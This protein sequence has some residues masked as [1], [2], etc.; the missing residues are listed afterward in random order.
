MFNKILV[1]NRSEI[2][3]R[4]MRSAQ[5]LGVRTVAVFSDADS[6]APHVDF[7]DEA[8]HIG[9]S[10]ASESYLVGAKII[11]AAKHT[12]AEAIHPGYGFLSENAD[13]AAACED[14]GLCFIGP[15][16]EVIRIMGSK[17]D[18]KALMQTHG[19]PVVPGFFG[20][21]SDE[22]LASEAEK[23]GFPVLIK[24]SAG[25]GGR[26]MRLVHAAPE[27][28]GALQSARREA[29][30]AFA[31][32]SVLLEKYIER[33]RH[34]EV[35][36]F[37]DTHGNIIHLFERDCSVQR[38]YQKLIEEA[39]ASELT[40]GQR[41]HIHQAA[42]TAGAAVG[43]V[44]A[45]TV[46]FVVD[47]AGD[48]YFIEMNTRLQVE[49]PVTEMITGRDLVALQLHVAS[50]GALPLQTEITAHGHALEL[51]LCA[52]DSA[53]DFAP[54]TGTITHFSVPDDD[55][56]IDHGIGAGLDVSPY[57]DSM[58]AKLIV[59][60]DDRASAIKRAIHALER[61]EVAGVTTNREFLRRILNHPDFANGKIDTHFIDQH[62][63][64]LLAPAAPPSDSALVAAALFLAAN[65]SHANVTAK[66]EPDSP[67]LANDV[68]RLNLPN[69]ERVHL[70]VGENEQAIEVEHT[71][72]GYGVEL[73]AASYQCFVESLNGV[74]LAL[75]M[76]GDRS[77][78]RVVKQDS[79][80]DVFINAQHY[81]LTGR[82]PLHAEETD[83]AAGGNLA[84]PM[85]GIV[86]EVFVEVG[87]QLAAGSP[88][89]LIEAMKIEHTITA[90]FDGVVSEIR[91]KAGDQITT[92]GVAL[93]VMEAAT[94]D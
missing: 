28:L 87:Q 49:H 66:G 62:Q 8:V 32:D 31:D 64:D 78:A 35:Q 26:G 56:R 22:T 65:R 68:Y 63:S 1:A 90:P 16:A 4:I 61:T 79:R 7:A 39:P 36:I 40:E 20:D 67:W 86:L 13:F 24:A 29:K 42:I 71:K 57:Y 12:G 25:G 47:K 30:S 89:M 3:L 38:R 69:R 85:P 73:P 84:A 53:R 18:A 43:Y 91:F 15:S 81:T 45:G 10:P 83:D 46:E 50:G 80:L 5:Q 34:I 17:R 54:S 75:R 27:F 77:R 70:S 19:V 44:G 88:I 58:I 82:D 11:A 33:P 41:D 52:E 6:K 55:V 37:G 23:I 76:D 94:V 72:D 14:A 93:A 92:E 21:V 48:V 9:P 59:H 74:D 60:G 51:R 2:A